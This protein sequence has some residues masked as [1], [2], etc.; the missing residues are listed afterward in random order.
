MQAADIIG[1]VDLEGRALAARTLIQAS[2]LA[3]VVLVAMLIVSVAHVFLI[4]FAGILFA[5]LFRESARWIQRTGLPEPVALTTAIIAP[6]IL[7]GVGA[8]WIAPDVATQASEL[9][10]RIPE[11]A[12]ELQQRVDS[13][14]WGSR[15]LEQQKTMYDMLPDES[16]AV[17]LATRAAASLYNATVNLILAL[18]LGVFLAIDP[19][20]YVGGLVR[21]VPIDRRARAREVLEA[22]AEA[23][24]GWLLS[25]LIAMLV[26]GMLTTAG[27]A[28]LGIDLALVL[29][30]VAAL[31]SFV[32]NVGPIIA[33]LPAALIAL[34]DSPQTLLYV[35]LL[36]SGIQILESYLLT[37]LLQQR[38]VNLPPALALGM[39][40]LF[41]VLAGAIGVILATPLTV[42]AMVMIRMWYV[43][44]VLGDRPSTPVA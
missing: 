43:E 36:Y 16:E 30:V 10:R 18:A 31:L 22:T 21:L 13:S 29:G 17:D 14:D 1:E 20:S 34:V 23:L 38:M 7:F 3:L 41:G 40:F 26:I 5:I 32:P 11:S 35:V 27:L 4:A 44:D 19:G 33:M 42:A 12:R 15:L 9:A 37:P 6:V 24:A 25:K 28:L 39:M 2:V 8:W